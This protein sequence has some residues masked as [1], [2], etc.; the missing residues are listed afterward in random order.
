VNLRTSWLACAVLAG[1]GGIVWAQTQT[2]TSTSKQGNSSA[3]ATASSSSRQG[4][5]SS[6]SGGTLAQ[7]M[8]K[9]THVIVY[10]AGDKWIEG[11]PAFEQNLRPHAEYMGVLIKKG[12]LL[13][14]GPWRDEPGGLSVLRCRSDEEAKAVLENDPAVKDGVMTGELKAWSVYFQGTGTPTGTG[15]GV[16]NRP[17]GG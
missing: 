13:L 11:K 7:S 14:G 16:T 17:P 6:S 2:S 3:S 12:I 8:A 1:A 10:A 9:P 15:P 5:S 4:A